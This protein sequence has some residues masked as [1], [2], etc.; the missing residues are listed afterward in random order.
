[1]ILPS[2]GSKNPSV[3]QPG[4]SHQFAAHFHRQARMQQRVPRLSAKLAAAETLA[5]GIMAIRSINAAV[6]WRAVDA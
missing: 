1:M 5:K 2:L 6:I 3:D 4:D